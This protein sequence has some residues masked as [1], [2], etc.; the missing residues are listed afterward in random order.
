MSDAYILKIGLA[1]E[2]AAKL[3]LFRFLAEE[4]KK[5][6]ESEPDPDFAEEV[7]ATVTDRIFGEEAKQ[8]PQVE[9]AKQ[10]SNLI[11]EQAKAIGNREELCRLLTGAA[12]NTCY[13]R[14]LRAGGKRSMFSNPFLAYIRAGR[15]ISSQS[16][17]EI[18]VQLY[19]EIGLL[20]RQILRPFDTM[21]S[22]GI[23]R[24][25][26]YSPNEREFY[27]AVRAFAQ[28]VGVTFS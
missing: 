9:F 23:L 2:N 5:Q 8:E 16:S 4:Y 19:G 20:G 27:D 18:Q 10:H 17:R 21:E 22:L 24:P 6:Y 26:P 3:G 28:R 11:T 12:Y 1:T 14:Y 13:A 7:A 25:L 15:D